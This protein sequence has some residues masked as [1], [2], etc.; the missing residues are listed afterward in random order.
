[1]IEQTVEQ[2]TPI[3]GTRPACRT[4]GASHATIYRRRR[5]PAPRPSRPRPKPARAL[6][7]PE[8]Q[9]V[10]AE[11]HSERF[12]D[13]APAQVWATLLDEG[14]YLASERTMY[15]ILAA[16]GEGGERRNQL[17]HP[18]YNKPELL[19]KRVNEVWSWDISKLRGPAKWTY[20]YL[21]VILDVFS[22]YV[23]GWTLQHRESGPLAE[24]LIDQAL[25][26]RI[27]P[28]QLTIDRGSSPPSRSPSC[29]PIS[30]SPR[31]TRGPTPRRTIPTPR[32]TSG[33]SSTDPSSLLASSRS[34]TPVSSAGHSS[35]GTTT[36]IATRA[37][38]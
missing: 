2:L 17:V 36:S 37:S 11:L 26:P 24:Q 22:R 13:C 14:R 32:P 4:L 28:D 7:E 1:M 12:V 10:L 23:V 25:L 5:P 30:G 15:R 29:S 19:A 21:Y 34:N 38:A 9:K 6:S 3:I 16:Q 33:R 27:G 8:R 31:H 18:P 35:T 20:F